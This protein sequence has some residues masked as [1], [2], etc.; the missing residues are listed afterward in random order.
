[1][2]SIKKNPMSLLIVL[3][4]AVFLIGC[5]K[6]ETDKGAKEIVEKAP[7]VNVEKTITCNI[8]DINWQFKDNILIF[9]LSTDLP[10]DSDVIVS[11]SRGYWK[12]GSSDNYAINY[13]SE[14]SKVKKYRSNI[15]VTIDDDVWNKDLKAFQKKMAGV[16][17]GFDLAKISEEIEISFI[18]PINQTN[19][20]FGEKNINLEGK[21]VRSKGLRVVEQ[22]VKIKKKL[23]HDYSGGSSVS[24]SPN[25]LEVGMVYRISKKIP[26]MPELDPVNPDQALRNII[27]LPPGTEVT[28]LKTSRKNNTLWYNVETKTKNQASST[29]WINSTALYG[30]GLELVN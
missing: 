30:Q 16:G 3:T 15:S 17:F 21:F 4:F 18:V 27:N 24:T 25:S 9:S 6:S 28:I 11:V 8:F 5:S 13:Y 19:P 10:D 26:L 20:L 1:M 2:L 29:G 12:K 7:V 22:E 23:G 14:K